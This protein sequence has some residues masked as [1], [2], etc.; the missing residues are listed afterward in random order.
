MYCYAECRY[1]ECRYAECRGADTPL[2]WVIAMPI[3]KILACW[4]LASHKHSSLTLK[5][6]D[7]YKI[8]LRRLFKKLG[9][10]PEASNIRLFTLVINTTVALSLS[11]IRRW[12]YLECGA[13]YDRVDS[14]LTNSYIRLD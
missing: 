12:A 14:G 10:Q 7:F 3:I 2:K 4:A 11:N 6:V 13:P 9:T 1:A 5:S 8:G